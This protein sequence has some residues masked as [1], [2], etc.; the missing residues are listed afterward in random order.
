M[1]PEELKKKYG[2][3][4]VLGVDKSVIDA[5]PARGMVTRRIDPQIT[6]LI[7]LIGR[8]L[9]PQMRCEAE[10]NPGFK[11]IIPYVMLRNSRTGEIYT[12]TRL[13]GDSRLQGKLSFGLGGHM[14]EGE[15][16][17]P[18]LLRELRE[19]VG[20]MDG[21]IDNI[22]LYGYLYSD[23]TEVD[24]VHLGIVYVVDTHRMDIRC[25][26]ADKLC[27]AWFNLSQL[28]PFREAGLMESWSEMLFDALICEEQMMQSAMNMEE[29]E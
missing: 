24:S 21:D 22:M 5:M 18:C 29:M 6:N 9:H 3:A 27:G 17:I 19:E 16:F 23:T 25:L 14:D 26:E 13:G 7:D 12:T 28:M 20:L 15:T 8:S 1:T 4:T 11:Q 2:E 10:L